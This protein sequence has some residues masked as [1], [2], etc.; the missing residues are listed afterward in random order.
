MNTKGKYSICLQYCNILFFPCCIQTKRLDYR[1]IVRNDH[2]WS[3][4][5]IVFVWIQHFWDPP[6]DCLIFKTV[7]QL[8]IQFIIFS[9]ETEISSFTYF[10]CDESW[11]ERDE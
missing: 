11:E 6:L 4:N 2:K 5:L 9:T 10:N 7:L 1:Y 3:F 8:T